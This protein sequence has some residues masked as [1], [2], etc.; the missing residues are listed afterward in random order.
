MDI[1]G[2]SIGPGALLAPMAGVTDNTFRRICHENGC[3]LSYTEMIY[4]KGFIYSGEPVSLLDYS[5]DYGPVGLQIFGCEPY[6]MA[7]ATEALSLRPFALID[8]NMGCPAKKINKGGDGAALMRNMKAARDVIRAVRMA[9][10]KPVTV[11][12]RLGWDEDISLEF[13]LMAE[14]AGADAVCI[15]GRTREQQY[16][17]VANMA[18]IARAKAALH[19]PVIANGD[20]KSMG[21][22]A[23]AL[24]MTHADAAM[25]GRASLGNPWV[26]AGEGHMPSPGDKI[27]MALR[28]LDE[29][30]MAMPEKVAVREMRKHI[31]W[32]LKGLPGASAVKNDINH[33]TDKAGMT[34]RL[35]SYRDALQHGPGG[36][37]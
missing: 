26:F 11:K 13:A 37:I 1:A 16:Q 24:D 29:S 14:D 28:H 2:L 20:I 7:R 4:A 35:L 31:A 32:Y 9:T 15:H 6:Y 23:R 19:I 22:A 36:N 33:V 5:G 17:G 27:D 21:E 34:G 18:P 8:I 3:A 30:C 25:I 10:D 12:M